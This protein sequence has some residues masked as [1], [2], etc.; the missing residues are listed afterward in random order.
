MI[1]MNPKRADQ[2]DPCPRILRNLWLGLMAIFSAV[3]TQA[4]AQAQTAAG[5]DRI[6]IDYGFV[7]QRYQTSWSDPTLP[8]GVARGMPPSARRS[9]MDSV[10]DNG[11]ESPIPAYTTS[12]MNSTRAAD[13]TSKAAVLYAID[14]GENGMTMVVSTKTSLRPGDCAAMER[15]GT[16]FNLRGVNAGFCDPSNQAIITGLR[17]VNL[18]A[19]Q[20]CKRAREQQEVLAVDEN[21]STTPSDLGILCDGS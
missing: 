18:A 7:T 14:L 3:L 11:D 1:A 9:G 15:S 20:R 5:A 6:G 21:Q 4:T 8:A 10:S 19:A 13:D 16:Y 17:S 12:D 2:V